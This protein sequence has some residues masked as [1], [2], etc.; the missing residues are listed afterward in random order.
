[1]FEHI[2]TIKNK[3]FN[4]YL[5]LI[6]TRKHK[7]LR[8]IE[9]YHVH[10]ILPKS[11]GGNDTSDNLIHLTLREHY[12]AHLLLPKFLTNYDKRKMLY[13][14]LLMHNG[15]KSKIR[16]NSRLYEYI[17]ISF[18]KNLRD[19]YN[20]TEPNIR[21]FF[22]NALFPGE[23][24]VD[25]KPMCQRCFIKRAEVNYIKNG[26]R[27]YRKHCLDCR[28]NKRTVPKWFRSGY[29]KKSMCEKCGFKPKVIEQ[30]TVHHI[31][32][33]Q[34]DVNLLNLKTICINC[35]VEFTYSLT[36]WK[37]GDLVPDF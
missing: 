30:L 37:Q 2:S 36:S 15:L 33:N 6:E 26:K 18:E 28:K 19:E 16:I 3:Y 23:L 12:I 7:P 34:A 24:A 9:T 11:L 27:H 1:M 25:R 13:S 14:L 21:P 35:D 10:H 32:G 20:A 8:T 4:W 17:R 22:Y 29:K 5:K 31:N